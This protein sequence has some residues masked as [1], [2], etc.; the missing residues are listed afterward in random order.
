[1]IDWHCHILPA[2][3]DGAADMEQSLAMAR[4]LAQSGFTTIYCTPHRMRG[5]YQ[6]DNRQIRQS[7]LDLQRRLEEESIVLT[8]CPGCEY[9]LDEYLLPSLDDPLPLGESRLILVE[10][11]PGLDAE[12][13]RQLLYRVV[14]KGFTPVIAHPERCHLLEPFTRRREGKGFVEVFRGFLPGGRSSS[15]EQEPPAAIA[16]PLLEYLRDLGCSFQGNL[17]SFKG[18]Y[19]LR[20][21]QAAHRLLSL[22]L[23]DRFGSDLHTHEQAR[24]VLNGCEQLFVQPQ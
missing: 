9:S 18:F 23:Y 8:L 12:K 19:G 10:I 15:C 11:L 22:G 17:G 5:R 20:V 4:A 21:Q 6:A 14:E 1:M 16:P 24:V 2:L 13:I 7:V 3:D